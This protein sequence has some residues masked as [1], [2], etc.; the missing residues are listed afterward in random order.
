MN[1]GPMFAAPTRRQVIAAGAGAAT[2]VLAPSARA[3][4]QEMEKA[5]LAFTGGATPKQGRVKVD[6][7]VLLESGASVP[8]KVTVESAMRGGDFV[9]AIAVFNERNPQPN[10]A[11]FHFSPRSGKAVA[12]TRIRLGDSQKIVAVA[13]MSDGSYYMGS[14]EV[15]VTLP[16]CAE[17]A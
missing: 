15:I 6:I 11:V 5:I 8:T 14:I 10:V 7:P 17:D 2:F 9:R 12:A 13:R 4:P 1:S 3:T 16:A